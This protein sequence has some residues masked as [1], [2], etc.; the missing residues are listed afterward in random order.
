M[1]SA[2]RINLLYSETKNLISK[3]LRY[4]LEFCYEKIVLVSN[5]IHFSLKTYY[6]FLEFHAFL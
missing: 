4:S 3:A 5:A 1:S 6:A 2:R